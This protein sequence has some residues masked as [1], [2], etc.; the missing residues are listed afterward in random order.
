M[1]A[2]PPWLFAVGSGLQDV[3]GTGCVPV[4]TIEERWGW[5]TETCHNIIAKP[6]GDDLISGPGRVGFGA[7]PW[8]MV[9]AQKTI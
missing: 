6:L 3:D 4:S 5:D 9:V 1:G 8:A 7:C 2:E